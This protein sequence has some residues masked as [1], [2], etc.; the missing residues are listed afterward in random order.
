MVVNFMMLGLIGSVWRPQQ[1][2]AERRAGR[3]QLP[4][5]VKAVIDEAMDIEGA[6]TT[7]L[8]VGD[9]RRRHGARRPG[10]RTCAAR[11]RPP[12]AH[13]R[14]DRRAV[15]GGGQRRPRRPLRPVSRATTWPSWWRGGCPS[16]VGARGGRP[17]RRRA[18]PPW[19]RP[20][21]PR[22]VEEH[23]RRRPAACPF[24]TGD[25][26]APE[27]P[28]A[29]AA[30]LRA[31]CSGAK[32]VGADG[33]R[34][35][36]RRGARL[37]LDQAGRRAARPPHGGVGRRCHVSATSA[38]RSRLAFPFVRRPLVGRRRERHRRA[39]RR[40]GPGGVHSRAPT[41]PS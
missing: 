25:V 10:R 20:A 22:L 36:R 37:L 30:R 11:S 21:L 35:G 1:R 41:C 26:V 31:R 32:A 13:A 8:S 2:E 12:S 24:R 4:I 19:W 14:G 38:S 15:R 39:E 23:R 28:R 27:A 18:C 40:R 33:R 7:P 29:T 3:T 34:C 17:A 5:D 6:R 9:L 16:D